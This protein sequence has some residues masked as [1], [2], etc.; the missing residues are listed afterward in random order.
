MT[1]IPKDPVCGMHVAPQS[2]A[3]RSEYEGVTYYFC[4][5]GCKK[6]F[7][8]EPTKYLNQAS[9]APAHAYC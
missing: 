6:S 5:L 1:S 2:A 7:D 4:C 9:T 8:K 3:A